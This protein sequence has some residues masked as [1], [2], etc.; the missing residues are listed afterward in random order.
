MQ[1]RV[2]IDDIQ[3][4]TN[5]MEVEV[6]EILRKR[7]KS[8]LRWIDD[9]FNGGF[10]R[11][12]TTLFTGTPGSGKTT[13]MMQLADSLT[14]A[15]QKV[16]FNTA[17]ESLYQIKMVVERLRLRNGFIAGQDSSME[18][19]LN[20]A[21]EVDADFLI[22]DSLQCMNDGK[23]GHHKNGKTPNRCLEMLTNWAKD[24][25]KCAFVIGQVS[26]SGQFK[27][28]MTLKHMVDAH[29]HLAL[30][31]DMKSDTFGLRLLELQKYRFGPG[32]KTFVLDMRE[33]GLREFNSIS[34]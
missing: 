18:D 23:Y 12:T 11:T 24:R 26:K 33:R 19:L 29:M 8:N 13:L 30:D 10:I 9:L 27:G 31:I 21:D 32:G 15:G 17:E 16:L 34:A 1:L 6:P 4:G 22:I 2:G 5:I 28:D 25:K 14:K 7:V 3:N 20:H